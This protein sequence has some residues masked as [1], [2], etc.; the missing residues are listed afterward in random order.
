MIREVLFLPGKSTD[1][2]NAELTQM[3]KIELRDLII[4][5]PGITGSVLK[6][7]GKIIWGMSA[8]G[9]FRL[10]TSKDK[11]VQDLFLKK[12]SETEDNI[13]DGIMA[14]ELIKFPQMIAGLVKNSG[15]QDLSKMLK[16]RFDLKEGTVSQ[17]DIPANYI[18]FPYDWRRTNVYTANRLKRFVEERLDLLR[19]SEDKY[20]N[21]EVILITHS[22]GGLIS[23][24][25]LEVLGGR[26]DC[27]ALFTLGTPHWGSMNAL[28]F[29]SNGY[30]LMHLELTE[31]MR[32][33]NAIYELLPTYYCFEQNGVYH[34]LDDLDKLGNIPNL[35]RERVNKAFKFHKA[36][37]EAIE[38]NKADKKYELIPIVG[39]SQLTY[40][41]AKFKDER[42][43]LLNKLEGEDSKN[44]IDGDG[45]VPRMSAIPKELHGTLDYDYTHTLHAAIPNDDD[46]LDKIYQHLIMLKTKNLPNFRGPEAE[47]PGLVLNIED[48][49][50][51]QLPIKIF[52]DVVNY[53]KNDVD[54]KVRIRQL[55]SSNDFEKI[56]PLR[57]GNNE[58][59]NLEP[60]YYEVRLFNKNIGLRIPN[61]ITD[62]FLVI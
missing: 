40:Q 61:P 45:T 29:I 32:S 36:I 31:V 16:K 4:V 39:V 38:K 51:A 2:L 3:S 58:I 37:E 7:N 17:P 44:V 6:K 1:P 50:L 23:R 53:D 25:Y 41:S 10:M 47:Y 43:Y 11:V 49:Y 60:G 12:D 59:E 8:S 14:T 30:H 20:A 42:I 52:A 18:E 33:F 48:M 9:L 34:K 5:V 21:A 62:Y 28:D 56:Y 15:Y 46:V 13:D 19:K 55:E 26:K 35:N 57:L 54:L 22:M 27:K 24:Y